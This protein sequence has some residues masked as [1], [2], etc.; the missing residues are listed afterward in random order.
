MMKQIAWVVPLTLALAAVT[1]AAEVPPP[2]V[3]GLKNPQ[4]VAV[5]VDG[6]AYV[7]VAGEIGTDGDGAVLAIVDG[8]AVP[9]ASGLDDPKGL[10]AWTDLLFA[11]DKQRV[12][13][14]NKTGKAD[15]F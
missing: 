12:W 6:R 8:Q 1:P 4:A 2:L 15:V 11:A 9:F 5:G 10:V 14:I 13:R 3:S 7:T